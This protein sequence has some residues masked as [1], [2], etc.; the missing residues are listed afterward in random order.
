M[1]P[2]TALGNRRLFPLWHQMVYRVRH[3]DINGTGRGPRRHIA[4]TNPIPNAYMHGRTCRPHRPQ[5]DHRIPC[6]Q[7]G[8]P[9]TTNP[10]T[11]IHR[12]GRGGARRCPGRTRSAPDIIGPGI[13]SVTHRKT[14][15]IVYHRRMRPIPIVAVFIAIDTPR[16][17]GAIIHRYHTVGGAICFDIPSPIIPTRK[18]K[19][20]IIPM[21]TAT[22]NRSMDTIL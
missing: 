12:R 16:A 13:I 17:G 6:T 14:L 7:A 18:N 22:R 4:V 11:F 19:R 3:A 20:S 2:K 8:Y 9:G 1:T 10:D 5:G 21:G 15:W